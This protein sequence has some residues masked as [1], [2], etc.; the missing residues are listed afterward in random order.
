MTEFWQHLETGLTNLGK[1]IENANRENRD[2]QSESNK[3]GL[4]PDTEKIRML[5]QE[6]YR[7]A[8]VGA[9]TTELS[10]AIRVLSDELQRDLTRR[11][12]LA[13]QLDDIAKSAILI[14]L[15]ATV[16]SYL[17][18]LSGYCTNRNSQF[19]SQTQVIPRLINSYFA[20]RVSKNSEFLKVRVSLTAT[21][22][23][24]HQVKEGDK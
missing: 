10:R 9:D 24:S 6:L 20:D 19:C 1:S 11:N 16:A 4:I 22:T 7:R 14:G 13:K 8:Q 2:W 15:V 21:R 18:G 17:T 12:S 5:K 3:L 23:P